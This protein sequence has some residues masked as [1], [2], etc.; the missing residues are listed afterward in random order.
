M[1][2]KYGLLTRYLQEQPDD[3]PVSLTWEEVDDL[4]RGL[5]DSSAGR[6]WWANTTGHSQAAAWLRTGRRITEVR[7][8]SAVVF[9][10]VG[11]VPSDDLA[12]PVTL[13]TGRARSVMDGV[14]ALEAITQRAGYASI[15]DAV[16]A[17]ALFLHPDTVRQTRGHAL[18]PIIRDS[19]RRGQTV[20]LDGL[21]EV[22][23]DDNSSPTLAFMWAA[24]RTKKARD[25][26]FN[27]LWSDPRDPNTYTALWNLVV[28]P[29]FLAKT[30]DGSNHPEVQAALRYRSFDLYGFFP[31]GEAP[32]QPPDRYDVL[33][34]L[35]FPDP[36]ANL[37][38]MLRARLGAAPK[39]KPAVA[40]RRL[41]WLFSDWQ[42]DRTLPGG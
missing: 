4:V 3:E 41:G 11:E 27:H 6:T 30:T 12:K 23:F 15:V 13:R 32:P 36:V 1:S 40:A 7:L 17:H 26:Q 8:G 19:H 2:S 21:R 34:W 39:C 28:T 37:E 25:V 9:S 31:D 20:V 22:M 10:P 29:A 14:A 18:F 5:P 33:S 16:A 38:A 42:P 35:P 24:Q